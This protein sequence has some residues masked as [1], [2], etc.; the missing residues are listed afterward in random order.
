MRWAY[1]KFIAGLSKDTTTL[2]LL[3]QWDNVKVEETN[4]ALVPGQSRVGVTAACDV[5]R[6]HLA[7]QTFIPLSVYTETNRE[8]KSSERTS[9]L[10]EYQRMKWY[11]LPMLHCMADIRSLDQVLNYNCCLS[12]DALT[13][14]AIQ[15]L[16][17]GSILE[18]LV[19]PIV[20]QALQVLV[21]NI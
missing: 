11:V 17:I 4:L 5:C 3:G 9:S 14:F 21:Y 13:A 1:K 10:K 2:K 20:S 8:T 7:K 15:F 16:N 12:F 19:P 6:M 18:G